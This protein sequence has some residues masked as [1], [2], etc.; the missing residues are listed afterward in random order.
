MHFIDWMREFRTDLDI[1]RPYVRV[2]GGSAAV[3]VVYASRFSDAFFAQWLCAW[4]PWPATG[5]SLPSSCQRVPREYRYFQACR[6]LRPEFWNS[7]VQIREDVEKEGHQPQFIAGF[8]AQIRANH[9]ICDLCLSGDVRWQGAEERQIRCSLSRQQRERVTRVMARA[10]EVQAGSHEQ[11]SAFVL[12]GAPGTGKSTVLNEIVRLSV[13]QGWLVHLCTPT[14]ALSEVFRRTWAFDA[15]VRVDTFDGLFGYLKGDAPSAYRL[16]DPVMCIV[17][18]I[19]L[20]GVR[21]YEYAM[22]CWML[23][24]CRCI[25]LF[26]GDF[27]QGDVTLWRRTRERLCLL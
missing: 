14:G 24:D 23:A 1:P 21:R 2:R 13:L 20:L 17:D 12:L 16:V 3:A 15:R 25:M 6:V 27:A 10:E 7:M 19:G 5:V 4:I 11:G 18:E 22:R 9:D 8:L 26:A